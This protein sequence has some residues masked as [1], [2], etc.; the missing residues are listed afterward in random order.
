MRLSPSSPSRWASYDIGAPV[1]CMPNLVLTL[2]IVRVP[3]PPAL[4]LTC[5]LATTSP[6]LATDSSFSVLPST[7][8]NENHEFPKVKFCTSTKRGSLAQSFLVLHP[9]CFSRFA[10]SFMK[11]QIAAGAKKNSFPLFFLRS[12]LRGL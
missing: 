4:L 8:M 10:F 11:L 5:K 2:V 1:D 7:Q 6:P 9:F 12:L 3:L